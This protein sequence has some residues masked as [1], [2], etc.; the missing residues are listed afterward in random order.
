MIVFRKRDQSA[1]RTTTANG[2]SVRAARKI[3]EIRRMRAPSVSSEVQ[4]GEAEWAF[5][6]GERVVHDGVR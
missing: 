6:V 3:D 5:M 4:Y 1:N 2:R